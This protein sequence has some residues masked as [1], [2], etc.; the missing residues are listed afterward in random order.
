MQHDFLLHFHGTPFSSS[1]R[2]LISLPSEAMEQQKNRHPA[3]LLPF[4]KRCS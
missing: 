4:F 1:V 2:K 3:G